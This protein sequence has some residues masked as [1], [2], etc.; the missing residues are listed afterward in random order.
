MRELQRYWPE[1]LT[2]TSI[3][4]ADADVI[5]EPA[6]VL[7][8]HHRI[9]LLKQSVE[10]VAGESSRGME[11]SEEEFLEYFLQDCDSDNMLAP[12]TGKSGCGKSHFI[13]WLEARLRGRSDAHLRHIIRIPKGASFRWVI[14]RI[15]AG[16]KGNKYADLNAS[17]DDA[18]NVLTTREARE[19]I[20]AGINIA[21]DNIC[22]DLDLRL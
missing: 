2:G 8:T 10:M 6:V 3:I 11:V 20:V 16:L 17:V 5:Q 19:W 4:N 18:G 1:R 13:V 12:I 9:T 22:T 14:K 21:L 7:A 15:L